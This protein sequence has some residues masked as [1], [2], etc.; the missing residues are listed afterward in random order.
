ME[1]EDKEIEWKFPEKDEEN[2]ET[3]NEEN[4]EEEEKS[5]SIENIVNQT[6]APTLFIPRQT[7]PVLETRPIQPHALETEL[8]ETPTSQ[9]SETTNQENQQ[10]DSSNYYTENYQRGEDYPE[11][12]PINPVLDQDFSRIQNRPRLMPTDTNL[13]TQNTQESWEK[14]YEAKFAEQKRDRR[15]F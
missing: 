8:Q 7:S 6:P 1:E 5:E 12:N 14:K 9:T 10:Y 4:L 13:M 11:I 15:R 3:E 2:E